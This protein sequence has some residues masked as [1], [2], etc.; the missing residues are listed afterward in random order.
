MASGSDLVMADYAELPEPEVRRSLPA[1]YPWPLIAGSALTLAVNVLVMAS[2]KVPFLGPA[3]GFWFLIVLP[4]YLVCATSFLDGSA[5][6]ERIGYGLACVIGTLMFAGLLADLVLPFVGVRRPL[7]PVPVVLIGDLLVGGLYLLRRRFPGPALTWAKLT[8]AR[9]TLRP[10]EARLVSGSALVVVLAVLGANRMNNNAG[11]QV[12][13]AALGVAV[14][15]VVFLLLWRTQVREFATVVTLY[16]LALS[17]LLM[18]SLRGWFVTGH[19]IQTEYQVFQLTQAHGSWQIGAF[20]NAYDACLSITILPTELADVLRVDGPYIYKLFFQLLFAVAPVLVYTIARRYW[21]AG[22]SILAAIYFIS[23]PTFFTD[24]PFINRQ[25]IGLLFVCAAI[26]AITNES[27]SI[28]M[29]RLAFIAACV[30]VEVSHYSSM[31]IFLGIIAVSWI[32]SSVLRLPRRFGRR[33]AS[34]AEPPL[35]ANQVRIA[36]LG[37]LL[38]LTVVTVGWGFLAT[39]SA[40]AVITDAEASIS[41]LL[42]HSAG[43][44]SGNVGYSLFFGHTPTPQQVINAYN[45]SIL[46][47]RS[48]TSDQTSYLE[49][50]SV[51]ARNQVKAVAQP[52]LP[53]TPVGRLLA[54]AHLPVSGINSAIRLGAA[55][56]EQLFVIAGLAFIFLVKR[57]RRRVGWEFFCLG[58][59][60]VAML[61]AVTVL[62]DVSVD[63]GILRVFQE[64]L[65]VIAPLLVAG[66]I[67][68]FRVFGEARAPRI[69]AAVAVG[70]FIS[71]T[72]L[73]PQVLGGYPAQLSLNNSGTYYDDYYVHTQEAAGTQWL[74]MQLGVLPSGVQATHAANRFLFTGPSSVTGQQFIE[75]A[76]PSLLRAHAWVIVDYSILHTGLASISYDGDNILYKYPVAILRRGK[77]LVY[78]NGGMEIYR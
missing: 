62:P 71:T 28:R 56:G 40:G 15:A 32:V 13:L 2:L 21:P 23:F 8:Q 59:G 30:G 60:A 29:R 50:A 49:S 1:R 72:G 16:L 9:R 51:A 47:L 43:T 42:G 7:D 41:G 20:H 17:L 68:I 25:E 76:F 35:W 4:V 54:D 69:A 63:Y 24:M 57:Q 26:L 12:S 67:A 44:R 45:T 66:S 19:D 3:L 36:G 70:I 34:H 53:L 77:D 33:R 14:L 10:K 46:K 6:A 48:R 5:P 55:D 58:F 74:S 22:V 31:Y 27:W 75:D 39:Q 61:G 38:V 78:D 37:S 11:N 18:T 52:L 65:V 73:L 64:S